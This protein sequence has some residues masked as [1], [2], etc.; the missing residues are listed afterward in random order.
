MTKSI[1]LTQGKF[2][3]VD[4]EDFDY[5][6]QFKWYVNSGYAVRHSEK[7]RNKIIQMHRIILKTPSAMVTDHINGDR[8]DN[9]KENLR[10]CTESENQRNKSKLPNNTTGYKGVYT[11][12]VGKWKASIC[13]HRQQIFLGVFDSPKEAAHAYDEAA[14]KHHG[15]FARINGV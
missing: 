10:A 2:S 4:D 13:V 5:I 15:I 3:Q 14:L 12:T 6:N 9:R 11:H 7:D 1:P 8:L